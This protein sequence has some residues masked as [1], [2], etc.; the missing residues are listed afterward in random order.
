MTRRPPC[1]SY[2]TCPCHAAEGA[3]HDPA[4]CP[5]EGS[6]KWRFN[7]QNPDHRKFGLNNEM[8]QL[9]QKVA[10]VE[11]GT[12]QAHLLDE[13]NRL[14]DAVTDV[15]EMPRW[16]AAGVELPDGILPELVRVR[17]LKRTL[18]EALGATP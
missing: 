14:L 15:L 9:R 2:C 13:V 8:N 12:P 10:A 7:Q 6:A 16:D 1:P 4:I 11:P 18:E 5:P 3:G 17:D